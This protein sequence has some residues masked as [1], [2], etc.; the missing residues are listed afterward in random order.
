MRQPDHADPGIS[1]MELEL[2]KRHLKLA[3]RVPRERAIYAFAFSLIL[4][5]GLLCICSLSG[6]APKLIGLFLTFT[7]ACFIIVIARNENDDRR[8]K[9]GVQT[10]RFNLPSGSGSE[11]DITMIST[12][13]RQIGNVPS[14]A[15]TEIVISLSPIGS[16]P[17]ELR[18]KVPDESNG[19][20]PRKGRR[21]NPAIDPSGLASAAETDTSSAPHSS[22]FAVAASLIT[23]GAYIALTSPFQVSRKG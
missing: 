20:V 2:W 14:A 11:A 16:Q 3:E 8:A 13:I 19:K 7:S 21:G 6:S 5:T 12:V 18:K 17:A 15:P 1:S 9:S 23:E 10:L 22:L 4:F